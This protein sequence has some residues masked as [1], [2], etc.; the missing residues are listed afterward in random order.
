MK[1]KLDENLPLRLAN[2]LKELGRDVHAVQDELLVGHPDSRREGY[3]S[4]VFGCL[5]SA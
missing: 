1:I 2:S 3:A 5:L 4:V